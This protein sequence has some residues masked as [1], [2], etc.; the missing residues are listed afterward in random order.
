MKAVWDWEPAS[1]NFES[2]VSELCK[3]AGESL[4]GFAKVRMSW[5]VKG[6]KIAILLITACSVYSSLGSK[7]PMGLLYY[8]VSV[9]LVSCFWQRNA[10]QYLLLLKQQ[11]WAQEWQVHMALVSAIGWGPVS[12][13]ACYWCR[14][15]THHKVNTISDRVFEEFWVGVVCFGCFFSQ[16]EN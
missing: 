3:A 12:L 9:F 2:N 13:A 15:E 8:Y 10:K 1:R 14:Q 16:R 5:T 7:R 6:G 4:L 11:D